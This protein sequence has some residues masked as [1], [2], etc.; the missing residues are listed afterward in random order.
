MTKSGSFRHP[1]FGAAVVLMLW[2][3]VDSACFPINSYCSQI[4]TFAITKVKRAHQFPLG[5]YLYGSRDDETAGQFHFQRFCNFLRLRQPVG[6][7]ARSLTGNQKD[8][9]PA[10]MWRVPTFFPFAGTL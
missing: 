10:I 9:I 1:G 8:I 4:I 3:Q 7:L 5:F 6:S 2:F